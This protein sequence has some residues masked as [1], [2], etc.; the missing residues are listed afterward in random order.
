[1]LASVTDQRRIPQQHTSAFCCMEA[2]PARLSDT[3]QPQVRSGACSVVRRVNIRAPQAPPPYPAEHDSMRL[4]QDGALTRSSSLSTSYDPST[5]AAS[6]DVSGFGRGWLRCQ[7]PQALGN[8]AVTTW[9]GPVNVA[10]RAVEIVSERQA[11]STST[12]ASPST[13]RT[14]CSS[15]VQ[16]S[17]V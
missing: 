8:R 3:G 6:A 14:P 4:C 13:R 1:V 7:V 17:T 11:L 16:T 9:P 10:P 2:R 5:D 12:C 15:S